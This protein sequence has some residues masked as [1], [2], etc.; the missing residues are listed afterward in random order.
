MTQAQEI[1][2]LSQK[3]VVQIDQKTET[4]EIDKEIMYSCRSCSICI[5]INPEY[6][7]KVNGISIN[8]LRYADV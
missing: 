7:N 5:L 2:I 8:N 6:G 3:A 1:L 4:V